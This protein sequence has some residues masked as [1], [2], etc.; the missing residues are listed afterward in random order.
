MDK[1]TGTLVW[2]YYICPREVWLMAHELNPA[3]DNPFIEIGRLIHE[4]S[5]ARE[6]KEITFGNIK[7]DILKREN[8]QTVVAEVKKSSRYEKSARMQLAFY[9]HR[10]KQMGIDAKGELLIPKEKKRIPVELDADIEKQLKRATTEIGDIISWE[11]PPKPEKNK[12]CGKC[13][14]REFCW[15]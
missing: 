7:F 11:V 14:Y 2:Y 13:A 6:K 4:D 1:I 10:L 3:Q 5:Y 9:L 8:K 12:F 15:A